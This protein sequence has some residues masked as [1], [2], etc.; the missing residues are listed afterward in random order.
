MTPRLNKVHVQHPV[1][2]YT[3]LNLPGSV[4]T[5]V[6]KKHYVGSTSTWN[7][8]GKTVCDVRHR[9]GV[10]AWLSHATRQN[11]QLSLL[12]AARGAVSAIAAG[13]D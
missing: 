5:Y 9:Q 12:A 13:N 8:L 11:V 10:T 2:C 4:H 7:H 6:N 3:C 1:A